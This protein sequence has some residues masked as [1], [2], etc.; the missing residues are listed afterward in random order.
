MRT[1]TISILRKIFIQI[2]DCYLGL[3]KNNV[4]HLDLK[5]DNILAKK[6]KGKWKLKIADFGLSSHHTIQ[7]SGKR[8]TKGYW[9]PE[10]S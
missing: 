2:I 4:A 10:Q 6:I 7:L 1:P 3:Y 5:P 9:S 8:G